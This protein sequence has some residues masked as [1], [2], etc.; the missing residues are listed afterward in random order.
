VLK[1]K[2]FSGAMRA[3]TAACASSQVS[4]SG[5]CLGTYHD[6]QPHARQPPGQLRRGQ[7]ALAGD[8]AAQVL[9]RAR[10]AAVQEPL[11][12][13]EF[14]SRLEHPPITSRGSDIPSCR[15][16]WVSALA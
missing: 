16:G 8:D 6:E 2:I 14:F 1:V 9:T 12:V 5:P 13:I 4:N 10:H 7:A 3:A 11:Q 15:T